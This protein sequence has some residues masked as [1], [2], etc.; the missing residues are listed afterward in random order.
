MRFGAFMAASVCYIFAGEAEGAQVSL[1]LHNRAAS[2][3]EFDKTFSRMVDSLAQSA[4]KPALPTKSKATSAPQFNVT[5]GIINT[6]TKSTY[7]RTGKNDRDGQIIKEGSVSTLTLRGC[8]SVA[9]QNKATEHYRVVK[10]WTSKVPKCSK[11]G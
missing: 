9:T 7:P 3:W 5:D 8:S 2:K 6:M 4:N 11:K 10:G 1:N